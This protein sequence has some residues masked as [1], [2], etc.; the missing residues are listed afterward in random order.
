MQAMAYWRATVFRHALAA[1]DNSQ[2]AGEISSTVGACVSRIDRG[3]LRQRWDTADFM[4]A[5]V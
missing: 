3:G 5:T 4:A 2:E 1:H